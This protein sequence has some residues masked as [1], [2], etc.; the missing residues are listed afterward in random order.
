MFTGCN[1]F[2]FWLGAGY[3]ASPSVLPI[4]RK[5]LNY[6]R[7]LSDSKKKSRRLAGNYIG[8]GYFPFQQ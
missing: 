8:H 6:E 2:G 5:R 7:L 4:C 1:W 3:A